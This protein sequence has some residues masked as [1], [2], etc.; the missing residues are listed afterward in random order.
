MNVPEEG[1]P[2]RN[3]ETGR[4]KN[5]SDLAQ[6]ITL[7]SAKNQSSIAFFQERASKASMLPEVNLKSQTIATPVNGAGSTKVIS[8]SRFNYTDFVEQALVSSINNTA[9]DLK[10]LHQ[11]ASNHANPLLR[12]SVNGVVSHRIKNL[13]GGA[14]SAL[15][16]V[17]QGNYSQQ[18][19]ADATPSLRLHAGSG[20]I[21]DLRFGGST[22]K[23]K[24][25]SIKRR[26]DVD[27]ASSLGSSMARFAKNEFNLDNLKEA[28]RRGN[29]QMDHYSLKLHKQS[30]PEEGPLMLQALV[31]QHQSRD[32]IALGGLLKKKVL[33]GV[34]G[35]S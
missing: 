25:N 20:D 10:N 24:H 2:R 15:Q 27:N 5:I 4:F 17:T 13:L 19:I 21:E 9:L 29:S 7:Q 14:S 11:Y 33:L 23:A 22:R 16:V 18:Q 12:G 30:H 28:G 1:V 8:S 32:Q 34:D 6:E 31:G 26:I 35:R 3:G